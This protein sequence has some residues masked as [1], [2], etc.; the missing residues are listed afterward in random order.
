[1][2]GGWPS[3]PGGAPA[4]RPG[5]RRPARRAARGRPGDGGRASPPRRAGG[6][7]V[8]PAGARAPGWG[9]PGP[10]GEGVEEPG[11]T[12]PAGDSGPRRAPVG[13][14]GA[15]A[16]GRGPRGPPDRRGPPHRPAPGGVR[17]RHRAAAGG[18]HRCRPPP[19]GGPTPGPWPAGHRGRAGQWGTPAAPGEA[20]ESDRP[21]SPGPPPRG[22]T[23][24]AVGAPGVPPAGGRIDAHGHRKIY[25]KKNFVT[26]VQQSGPGLRLVLRD[27]TGAQAEACFPFLARQTPL[28]V[29]MFRHTRSTLRAYQE[30]GMAHG[31]ATRTPEDLPVTFHT[32]SERALYE[33]IDELCHQFYRLADVLPEERNGVGF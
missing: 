23:H 18:A 27:L 11:R 19:T 24:A 33:R 29:Y 13:L 2:A 15:R 8:G 1:M 12:P 3:L 30:R 25:R 20:L 21:H 14:P 6:S 22:R 28:A 10:K 5:A 7:A 4:A 16:P 26:H 9:P 17:P 32:V 31:L